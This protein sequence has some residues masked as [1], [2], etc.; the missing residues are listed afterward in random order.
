MNR[1]VQ[2]APTEAEKQAAGKKDVLEVQVHAALR[3]GAIH[4]FENEFGD[5]I[6]VSMW[7]WLQINRIFS[8]DL[9]V[10][11]MDPRA[12]YHGFDGR[13][14]L[15]RLSSIQAVAAQVQFATISWQ[16][17]FGF[18]F[19]TNEGFLSI[20]IDSS[21]LPLRTRELFRLA[22][23]DAEAKKEDEEEEFQRRK[24]ER[25]EQAE[26]APLG[27]SLFSCLCFAAARPQ[28][29]WTAPQS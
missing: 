12:E 18:G 29:V 13:R 7:S 8:F 9:S 4:E 27:R 10:C 5:Y 26:V 6:N 19:E 21:F 22:K 17:K 20:E 11:L 3:L 15:R 2:A 24:R 1:Q 23:I 14:R 25:A 16:L 28:R